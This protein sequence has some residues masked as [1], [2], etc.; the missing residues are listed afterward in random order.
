M[1]T[2]NQENKETMDHDLY[3]K[4]GGFLIDYNKKKENT[5]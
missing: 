2:L 4:K 5:F 1:K 3:F